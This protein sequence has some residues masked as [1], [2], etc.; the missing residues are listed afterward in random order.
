MA[1]SFS[2]IITYL[3]VTYIILYSISKIAGFY[4]ISSD[5]YMPYFMFYL[6]I[7]LSIIIVKKE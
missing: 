4:S 1:L 5:S 3:F 6:F 7:M 2:E